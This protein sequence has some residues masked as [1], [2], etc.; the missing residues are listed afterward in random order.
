LNRPKDGSIGFDRLSWV[1]QPPS[2][3]G[4]ADLVMVDCG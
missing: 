3:L 2:S 4:S 1:V